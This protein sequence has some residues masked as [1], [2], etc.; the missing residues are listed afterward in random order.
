MRRKFKTILPVLLLL[1]IA[2]GGKQTSTPK[3]TANPAKEA[4]LSGKQLY[5]ADCAV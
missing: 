1:S 2:A 5:V 4:L 3:G